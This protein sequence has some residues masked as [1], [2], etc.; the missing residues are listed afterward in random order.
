[1]ADDDRVMAEDGPPSLDTGGVGISKD[2]RSNLY[3][4]AVDE[5]S[6]KL[7]A[8][9]LQLVRFADDSVIRPREGAKAAQALEQM[10]PSTVTG[11]HGWRYGNGGGFNEML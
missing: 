9:R 8:K 11:E 4:D 2:R 10:Q 1:M 5:H 6:I 7:H 3:L